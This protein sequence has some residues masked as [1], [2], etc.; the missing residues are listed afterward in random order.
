MQN[1]LTKNTYKN[2]NKRCLKIFEAINIEN[3]Q[4]SMNE[5]A[6]NTGIND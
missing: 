6:F 1:I 3:K 4:L 5:I 2:N